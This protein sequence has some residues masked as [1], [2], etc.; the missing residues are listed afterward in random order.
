V[1]HA[2]P[3]AQVHP[4]ALVGLSDAVVDQLVDTVRLSKRQL[5]RLFLKYLGCSP[6]KHYLHVRLDHARHPK[7]SSIRATTCR[8]LGWA[9]PSRMRRSIRWRSSASRTCSRSTVPATPAPAGPR[10]PT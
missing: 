9:T 5:E 4:L 7:V 2:E 1:G 8:S 6:A 10:R 3:H